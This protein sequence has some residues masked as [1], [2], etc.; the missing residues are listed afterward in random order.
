VVVNN[1]SEEENSREYFREIEKEE[2]IRVIDFSE[3]FHFGKLY[4]WGSKQVDGKY[5][6]ILNNDI[7]VRNEG[8][9]ESMLE[10]IQLPEVGSVGARLYYKDGRIQHAG[11]IVGAGG[12]AAHSHRLSNEDDFGYNGA[13]VNIRNYLAVTGACMLVERDVFIEMGGFDERFDPAYQDVDFGIRLFEK[14]LYNVYTPYSELTHYESVTRFDEKNKEKLE[15]DEVNAEKLR[16][17]WPEYIEFM[18]GDDPF[19]NENLS[20]AHEDFR[21]K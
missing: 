16:K 17:K 19:F 13:I 8:W 18:G 14:D 10:W 20:Y 6:L 5:M 7:K 4:N 2:N 15:K 3:P 9:L 21:L 11:V 12:A 1:R